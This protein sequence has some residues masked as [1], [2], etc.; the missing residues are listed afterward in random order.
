[1]P[2][3][4]T[5]G[6]TRNALSPCC[7]D[8]R[9]NARPV[10]CQCCCVCLR[11]RGN[12]S[13]SQLWK[14]EQKVKGSKGV[15]RES[16]RSCALIGRCV[17]NKRQQGCSGKL[18]YNVTVKRVNLYNFSEGLI[19]GKLIDRLILIQFCFVLFCLITIKRLRQA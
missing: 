7:S 3:K 1:M 19:F 2:Q 15:K 6:G 13:S 16:P 4:K 14:L 9:I 5:R 10:G 12:A 11:V 8:T 18:T 17:C